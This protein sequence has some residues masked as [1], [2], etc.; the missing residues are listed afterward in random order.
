VQLQD[1]PAKTFHHLLKS[2]TRTEVDELFRL[3]IRFADSSAVSG[4]R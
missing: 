2:V 4:R 1:L 3:K